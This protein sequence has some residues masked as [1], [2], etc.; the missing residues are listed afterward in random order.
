[1]DFH[2]HTCQLSAMITNVIGWNLHLA[3]FTATIRQC[4]W[5]YI[6]VR[7]GE[8]HFCMTKVKQGNIHT[9]YM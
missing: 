3:E 7:H 2:F 8:V 1:M 4:D 9:T 6:H 5:F